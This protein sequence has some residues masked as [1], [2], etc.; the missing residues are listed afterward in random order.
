M[1]SA[2]VVDDRV[3]GSQTLYSLAR[4]VTP[5]LRITLWMERHFTHTGEVV[6]AWHRDLPSIKG[7]QITHR[8]SLFSLSGTIRGGIKAEGVNRPASPLRLRL[9][10]AVHT[11][12]Q[13]EGSRR[14]HS[15]SYSHQLAS[16][17]VRTMLT[18]QWT[19]RKPWRHPSRRA[20]SSCGRQ[21]ASRCAH[22][23]LELHLRGMTPI[24]AELSAS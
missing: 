2:V 6:P 4:Q 10:C 8:Y 16:N 24:S 21:S 18:Q 3:V 7:S 20:C 12:V 23:R 1:M 5:R 11:A 14:H 19:G 17:R 15:S 9:R 22:L 13:L